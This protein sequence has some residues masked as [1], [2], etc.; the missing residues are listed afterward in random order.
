MS[1]NINS[2]NIIGDRKFSF[3][4]S[5]VLSIINLSS[6]YNCVCDKITLKNGKKFVVKFQVASGN[7]KYHS[8]Y[9]EGKSL[10]IMNKKFGNIF[11]KVYHLEKNLFIINW[12]ENNNLK[13]NN[14]EEELAYYLSKIHSDNNG[15]FGF[16]FNSPIGGIEQPCGFENSWVNFFRK[17]RL[18]FIF[19]KIN[20]S[21]PMPKDINKGIEKIINK[22]ETFIPES[23]KPS[24]I[25]GDLWSGNILFNN[26]RLAGLIDPGIYYSNKELDLSSLSFLNVVSKDF[27]EKYKNFSNIENDFEERKGI[28]ELYY[29]LL[30]VYLWS[31]EYIKNTKEIIKRYE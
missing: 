6:S 28:Y 30:N 22:L 20:Y 16:D 19:D 24:L 17:K 27:I 14:S 23:N 9:Y 1:Q 7:S 5:D 8:I 2:K 25:H 29:A 18:Q 3:I 10:K 12:I 4:D 15:R 26:G 13:N 21:N 11:P 31:R